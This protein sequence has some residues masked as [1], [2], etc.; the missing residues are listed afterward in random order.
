[1]IRKYNL[2]PIC[3]ILV[4]TVIGTVPLAEL[5]PPV[6]TSL[7]LIYPHREEMKEDLFI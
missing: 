7:K 6:S 2:L 4:Y 5:P 1:M 3:N